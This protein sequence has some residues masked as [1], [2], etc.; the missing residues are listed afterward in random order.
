M[1]E[2]YGVKW[3]VLYRFNKRCHIFKADTRYGILQLRE[4]CRGAFDKSAMNFLPPAAQTAIIRSHQAK[5][6]I[7]NP[8]L[9]LLS[10]RQTLVLKH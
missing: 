7:Y 1:S 10:L 6:I 8:Q 4:K 2:A 9:A 5:C 3:N